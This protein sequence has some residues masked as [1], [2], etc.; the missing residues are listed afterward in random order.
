MAIQQ[1]PMQALGA[2]AAGIALEF[3]NELTVILSALET[4][5]EV[6]GTEHPAVDELKDLKQA[7]RRCVVNTESLLAFTSRIDPHTKP[8]DLQ[9]FFAAAERVLPN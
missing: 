8:F 1:N 2:L 6:L 4:V 5:M 9:S 3:N 7:A